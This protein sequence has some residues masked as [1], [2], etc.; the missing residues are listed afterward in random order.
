MDLFLQ[1]QKVNEI[2]SS[3]ADNAQVFGSIDFIVNDFQNQLKKLEE[4]I[5]YS[6]AFVHEALN[7]DKKHKSIV[8]TVIITFDF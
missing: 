5:N 7:R 4:N 8:L 1:L 3:I 6:E 2:V